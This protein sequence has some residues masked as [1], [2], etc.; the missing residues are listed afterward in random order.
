MACSLYCMRWFFIFAVISSGCS[1]AQVGDAAGTDA[2][3]PTGPGGGRLDG[4]GDGGFE[5][6]SGEPVGRPDTG[7]S[8][9]P[10]SCDG[11]TA[12]TSFC[13]ASSWSGVSPSV[14]T[15]LVVPAGKHIMLD[16]VAE[17]RTLTIEAGGCVTAA[18]N[19]ASQLTLH[20]NLV[21][22][23]QLDLGRPEERI[24]SEHLVEILFTGMDDGDYEGQPSTIF[25]GS[26]A[27]VFGGG[28]LEPLEVKNTDIG[29]WIV[30][31]GIVT[32]A[33]AEKKA[34]S[35]LTDGAGPGDST[36]EVADASGWQV[37]DRIALTPTADRSQRDH[38]VQFDEAIVR[39]VD[40]NVVTLDTAPVFEHAGC[41]DC[42]RRGEAANLSR[43]VVMRSADDSAHAHIAV[44]NQGVLQLDSVELRWL[45]PEWPEPTCGGPERR[46]PIHFHQL[47]NAGDRSFIRH[48]SIWGGQ[49]GFVSVE[50]THGVELWDIA[51]Y[52]TY[53]TGFALWYDNSACGT[54]CN[55]RQDSVSRGTV[56]TDILGAKVGVSRRE[57]G[58][59]RIGHR[60][61]VF[62]VSGGEGT[63]CRGCVAT[64][65]GFEGSGADLS[66]FHWAEGGSG[67]PTDFTFENNVAHNNDGHGAQVW[68]NAT[69]A[70]A[71][72]RHNRFW[73]NEGFG[74]LWGAY[75]NRYRIADFISVDSGEASIGAKAVP[76]D[77]AIRIA[78]ATIDQVR[79]LAY[80]LVQR[81][82]NIMQNLQ[83][84][85]E[86]NVAFTQIHDS[87]EGGDEND[88]FDPDCTRIWLHIVDPVFPSGVNPFDFGWTANRHAVWEVRGFSHPDA[89]YAD[90]PV[91]FDLYRR[92]NEVAGGNYDA[93]FDAWVV[94]R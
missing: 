16:C 52:D 35:F 32:A 22:R 68:H 55:D 51:G 18:R 82:P 1:S 9:T 46:H 72:Y 66:A 79:V 19:T 7:P 31:D 80:V 43:N 60:H 6:D 33:G 75:G 42:M 27:G 40:G 48:T 64:G 91:N 15:D 90:L 53:G 36:F 94:P 10:P 76:S 86:R 71:P 78:N 44:A 77:D 11:V 13:D 29:L 28:A 34:W 50:R 38:Y 30:D 8:W 23:G 5:I 37:G 65:S 84:T 12:A 17:A 49:H 14:S 21:V 69:Q 58:C 54:R 74:I 57:E 25:G 93:R 45:G 20:G 59:L 3:V 4:F 92:D 39:T 24:P 87:C 67:R 47:E 81:E 61:T 56:M 70:Q 63:G 2:G 41:T 83:F 88:P 26:M 85:G 89:E 73:T 62:V